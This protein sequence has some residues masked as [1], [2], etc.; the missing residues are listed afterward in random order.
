MQ[1]LVFEPFSR[2]PIQNVFTYL[3]LYL[4]VSTKMSYFRSAVLEATT[5]DFFNPRTK[6][7]RQNFRAL[8]LMKLS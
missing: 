8:G 4:S 5:A 3:L 7:V 2:L 6:A 1:S